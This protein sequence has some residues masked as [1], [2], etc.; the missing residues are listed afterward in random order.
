MGAEQIFNRWLRHD[1]V[2]ANER[3]T[4][5]TESG[6]TREIQG[7][8]HV[9]WLQHRSHH[10]ERDR[11]SIASSGEFVGDGKRQRA[12]VVRKRWNLRHVES[13]DLC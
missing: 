6:G 2:V 7:V 11:K 1:A 8:C 12:V 4:M 10:E 5:F 3:G 13:N 9:E